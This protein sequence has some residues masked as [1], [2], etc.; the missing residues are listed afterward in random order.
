MSNIARSKIGVAT[1]LIPDGSLNQDASISGLRQAID[2]CIADREFQLVVDLAGVPLVNSEALELL[3]DAQNDLVRV[4][5]ELR[6]AN[7]NAVVSDVLRL[8]GVADAVASVEDASGRLDAP[9]AFSPVEPGQR[10][11]EILI[12]RGAVSEETIQEA[13][14]VQRATGGRL[15]QIMVDKGWLAEKDLLQA[16]SDQ[17]SIPLV[18]LRPGTYDPEIARLVDIEIARRLKVMPLFRVRGVLYLATPD[19]QSIPT[20][21]AVEDLTQLKVRPVI[22]CTEEILSCIAEAHTGTTDLSEYV[23]DLESDLELVE[24]RVDDFAAIDEQAAG[25]PVVNLINGIIQRA[26]RDRASDIHIELSRTQCRIRMRIDGVL[27]TVMSPPMEVHP[28]LVSR[29]KVMANLDIAERRLP[30]DGRIQVVTQ[31]RVIDLRFSSLPGIFGEKVVLRVLEKSQA[32][33][34]IER[35]GMSEAHQERFRALLARSHGLILVTGPTGSGKTTSLY[36]AITHLNSSEKNII[37]IEDPVE[38]QVEGIN[39]NQVRENIGLSFATILKHSLR[40]DPDIVMVGEIRER[41][42]AEIAVQAALTGHLVLSTLHTNDAIGA[43]TRM[44]DMRIEPFLLSSALIGVMAQRLLREVCPECKTSYVAPSTAF[45]QYGVDVP[46]KARLSKGRGCPACYDS[47]YRGRTPIH[48]IIECDPDLQRLI[49][50]NPSRTD[51][52]AYVR[53]RGID[54]LLNDGIAR[55]LSGQTTLEE[56]LRAVSA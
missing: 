17:L 2:T 34:D 28:A 46:E 52:D 16:L 49:V 27:Y 54:T 38:Y 23:G 15:A 48:E 7:A 11:G 4:G 12:E 35:L 24:S 41:E 44:L 18:W 5:G 32:I 25:S 43:V 40:Q 26:V 1:Y 50:A 56:M 30:Q 42:T 37:T 21:E 45:S 29:L 31:G 14:E 53:E 47:G 39:Q 55:A 51:L 36:A 19:P 3:L 22:A 10:I 9:P 13:L 8:S 20:M 6:L 33:L